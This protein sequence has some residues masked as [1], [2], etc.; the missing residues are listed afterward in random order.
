MSAEVLPLAGAALGE[1]RRVKTEAKRN[2]RTVILTASITD[3][4][5]N[6]DL[7]VQGIADVSEAGAVNELSLI[8]GDSLAVT[9]ELEPEA[10]SEA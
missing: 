2:L 3:T 1:L 8:N 9:A 6:I 4:A 10:P 7:L 5:E